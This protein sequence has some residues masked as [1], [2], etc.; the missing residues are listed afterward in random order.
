M[1]ANL[2]QPSRTAVP[3]EKE[4]SELER[5]LEESDSS[6]SSE[7]ALTSGRRLRIDRCAEGDRLAVHTADDQIELEVVLTERGPLLRFRAADLVVESTRSVKI[8]CEDFHVRATKSILHD[9]EGDLTQRAG[10]HLS[11][12][13]STCAVR[14]TRGDV[15]I[16]ANDDVRVNGERVRLNC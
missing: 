8:D 10:S 11:A 16:A 12:Q 5:I 15:R 2:G 13:G 6:R 4:T 9:S 14:S 7:L 1:S 3:A